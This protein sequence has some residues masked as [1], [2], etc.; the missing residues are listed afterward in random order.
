M[1]NS[2]CRSK[3]RR[4]FSKARSID[5]ATAISGGPLA[6]QL[7]DQLFLLGDVLLGQRDVAIGLGQMLTFTCRIG[8]RR[9]S[10]PESSSAW[11]LTPVPR[12]RGTEN[13][14]GTERG[15]D[16]AENSVIHSPGDACAEQR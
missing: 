9:L 6:I 13:G 15:K 8:H 10:L 12:R 11:G 4:V 1:I 5:T 14:D 3:A 2:R 7:L 16:R